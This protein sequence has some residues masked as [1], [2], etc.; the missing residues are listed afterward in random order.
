MVTFKHVVAATTLSV[1]M[2]FGAATPAQAAALS[3]A[4]INAIIGLL[5]TFGVDQTVIDNVSASLAGR[6]IPDPIA[7]PATRTSCVNLLNNIHLGSTD[8]NTNG[9]VTKL[10]NYLITEGYL[11]GTPTGYYGRLTAQ[12]VGTLQYSFGLVTGTTDLS[13]GYTGSRTRAAIS[14]ATSRGA[15]SAV[16]SSGKAPLDVTFTATV[17][18]SYFGGANI[19]FGDGTPEVQA[20][21]PGGTCTDVGTKHTYSPTSAGSFKASL[22]GIGQNSRTLLGTAYVVITSGSTTAPW[23]IIDPRSLTSTL[24]NPTISGTAKNTH[25]DLVSF[26]LSNTAGDS[27]YDSGALDVVSGKWSGKV[28]IDLAPGSYTVK[29]LDGDNKGPGTVLTTGTLVVHAST[30]GAPTAS[31]TVN[32]E[33]EVWVSVGSPL[34]Y[35]WSSTNAASASS[36]YTVNTP[37]VCASSG[38]ADAFS[39]DATSRSGTRHVNA[40][41]TCRYNRT[42]TLTY[43]VVGAGGETVS[44]SVIIHVS[45]VA[46]LSASPNPCTILTGVQ[47]SSTISW[48]VPT[49]GQVVQVWTTTISP[50]STWALFSC[51]TGPSSKVAPWIPRA[52]TDAALFHI[53]Q[54]KT[55][56]TTERRSPIP[57]ATLTVR[58]DVQS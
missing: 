54:T 47:C 5:T 51:T 50:G 10:Q 20:C 49:P 22:V 34:D 3:E 27:I 45:L 7:H 44:D 42:Y 2:L 53:F 39:L 18:S 46:T 56:D 38:T 19:D 43:S 9:E 4:Q 33:K 55:C 30:A 16:P 1:I 52:P 48:K 23:A 12:A 25:N 58:G 35:A 11:T 57:D 21:P 36:K 40:I 32:G 26:S 15:L 6:V 28:A 41:A 13:Y 31:L 17:A 29:V 24:E 37:D 8:A 14:C